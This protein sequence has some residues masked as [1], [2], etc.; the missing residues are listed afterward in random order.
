[1]HN[2][3]ILGK[4]YQAEKESYRRVKMVSLHNS[5]ISEAIDKTRIY[6]TEHAE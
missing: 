2:G 3:T 4:K 1:M 6:R 5:I